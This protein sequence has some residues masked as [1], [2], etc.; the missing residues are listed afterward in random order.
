MI[1]GLCIQCI[2][3]EQWNTD[4]IEKQIPICTL[5]NFPYKIEHTIQWSRD[6]FEG[7]F[8]QSIQTLSAYRDTPDY[9]STLTDAVSH[10][11]AVNQLYD[12]LVKDPCQTAE[13]CVRWAARLFR[14]NFYNEI[15]SIL[16]QF[17]VRFSPI[18]FSFQ[19]PFD[20]NDKSNDHLIL[21]VG[22]QC[23]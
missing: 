2:Q 19:H 6:L 21:L 15:A 12:L 5:K 4:W 8:T 18:H 10:D 23:R 20:I 16:H 13:D 1:H 7:L 14:A 9:L 22:G 17:P 3:V 11:E